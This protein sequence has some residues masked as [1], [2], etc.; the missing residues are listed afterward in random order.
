MIICQDYS[1]LQEGPPIIVGL[2][3]FSCGSDNARQ[4]SPSQHG[5]HVFVE[6]RL[7]KPHKQNPL[8]MP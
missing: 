1:K 2:S 5:Y 3:E 7:Q 4:I 8:K 6:F